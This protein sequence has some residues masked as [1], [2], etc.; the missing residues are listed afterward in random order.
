M[1]SD[2]FSLR[3][4]QTNDAGDFSHVGDSKTG[5]DAREPRACLFA[6]LADAM[7]TATHEVIA[8]SSNEVLVATRGCKNARI[9]SNLTTIKQES[10]AQ[11]LLGSLEVS[12]V[13]GHAGNKQSASHRQSRSAVNMTAIGWETDTSCELASQELECLRR[14]NLATRAGDHSS[15]LVDSPDRANSCKR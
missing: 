5:R 15:D 10:V 3:Q 8:C 9:Q 14:R 2:H 1:Q 13:Q 12:L 11:T 4:A 7:E 6:E